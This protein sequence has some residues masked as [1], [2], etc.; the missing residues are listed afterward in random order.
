MHTN[1]LQGMTVN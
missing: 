1:I